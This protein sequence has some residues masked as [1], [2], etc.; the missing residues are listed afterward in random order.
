LVFL[1]SF[2]FA[3]A[4]TALWG[5][6]MGAQESIMRA[7]IADMVAADKRG[8]AYGIFNTGYGIFWFLGSALMGYLYDISLSAIITFSVLMQL[9]A[10]PLLLWVRA[11][12]R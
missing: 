11:R 4:G 3:L 9:A 1:G 5:V 6:G 10:I 7:A 8:S 2:H 12:T